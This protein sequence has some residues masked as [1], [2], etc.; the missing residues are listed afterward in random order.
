MLLLPS[1]SGMRP[2]GDVS[3][4]R[5]PAQS[6]WLEAFGAQLLANRTAP[7]GPE[8]DT[9]MFVDHER[10]FV[11]LEACLIGLDSSDHRS[12]HVRF[13]SVAVSTK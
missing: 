10:A 13:A 8:S 9:R 1:Y 2:N 4:P 12:D 6:G 11:D 3:V 7:T 5:Q